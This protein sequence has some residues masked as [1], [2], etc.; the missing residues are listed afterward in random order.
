[1]SGVNKATIIGHLGQDPTVKYFDDGSCVVNFTVATSESWKDKTTGE[2]KEKTEWHRV[3]AYRAI[4]E[5][6][7]KYL[8]KGKQ[9]YI[10]GKLQTREWEKDGVKHYTTEIIAG[11]MQM[12]GSKSD[13]QAQGGGGGQYGGSQQGG[14]GYQAPQG[15]GGQ[16]GGGYQAPQGGQNGGGYGGGQQQGYPPEFREK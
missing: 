13:G 15:Q 7:A 10:E 2:K 12:L 5:I 8:H 11:Q 1:M 6:C 3:T 14:D 16:Y 9:V 4:A